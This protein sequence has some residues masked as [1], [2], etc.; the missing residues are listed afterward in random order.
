[1]EIITID[2]PF[3]AQF[4]LNNINKFKFDYIYGGGEV[5]DLIFNY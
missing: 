3:I 2:L 5:N 4:K 1:M